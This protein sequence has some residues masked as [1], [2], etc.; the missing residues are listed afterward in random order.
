M[1]YTSFALI[2]ATLLVSLA[3]LPYNTPDTRS[4]S[5]SLRIGQASFF[6]DSV[7]SDIDR[8]LKLGTRRMLTSSTNYVITENQRL[9]EP[10]ENLSSAMVN[11]SISGQELDNMENVTV[12]A[13]EKNVEEIAENSGYSLNASVTKYRFNSSFVSLDASYTVSGRLIDPVTLSAFN[14]TRTTNMTVSMNGIEDPMLLLSSDGNYV[15]KYRKCSFEDPLD[16]LAQAS[17]FA[18]GSKQGEV[19]YKPSDLSDVQQSDKK[20]LVVSDVDNYNVNE[21]NDFKAVVSEDDNSTQGYNVTYAFDTSSNVEIE[22]NQTA[23]VKEGGLWREDLTTMFQNNCYIK[24]DDGPDVI[25]RFGNRKV[26][27][28]GS[29]ILTLIDVSEL[30]SGMRRED[31]A[32]GFVYFN[33]SA[34]YGAI[35]EISGVSDEYSWFRLDQDHIDEW[36]ANE[37]VK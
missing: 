35:E 29:G 23:I 37:L 31:S 27:D 19:A 17:D 21:V 24:D 11:A 18:G 7:M 36:N 30:P 33:G 9:T 25:D 8:S 4:P 32:V 1:I 6:L 22:G 16:K 15:S 13:W 28:D 14:R 12:S 26:N 5:E 34:D 10:V 3:L 20:I 2:A